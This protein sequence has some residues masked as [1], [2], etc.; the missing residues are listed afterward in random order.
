MKFRSLHVDV[1]KDSYNYNEEDDEDILGIIDYGIKVHIKNKSYSIDPLDPSNPMVFGIGP[2]AGGIVIGS[3]RIVFIFKS[4]VSMGIH[5]SELG[6]A[7]FAFFRTGLDGVVI[8]GKSKD[9]SIITI[10]S[11]DKGDYVK[12]EHIKEEEL[13]NIYNNYE[14][15]K[16][17][18]ALTQYIILKD[19]ENI[20]KNRARVIVVGPSAF[21][22]RFAGI[23]SYVLD[24]HNAKITSVSDSASRGGGGTVLA[25]GHNVVGIVVGGTLRRNNP[26]LGNIKIMNE[27]SQNIYKKQYMPTLLDKTVKYRF[28]P[29]MKTGGTF[30]VNYVHYKELVPYLGYN[31]IYY[32]RGVRLILHDKI[33]ENY[34]KPFQENVFDG[35]KLTDAS[36]NCGEPCSVSCKKIYKGTKIDYEPAHG[37]GPISGIITMDESANLVNLLDDLGL[38]AIEAGHLISWIFDLID[39]GL[40]N[41]EEV[42]LDDYPVF[43]PERLSKETSIKNANL[44][45]K[46]IEYIV[47]DENNKIL[48][49]ISERGLRAAAKEFDDIYKERVSKIGIKY[50]DLL[51]YAPFGKEGY[52]TPNYYWSP[53]VLAPMYVLGK[54]WTDYSPSFKEPEDYASLSLKRAIFEYI[55]ANAGFCRFHRGWAEELMSYMYKEMLNVNKDLY[56][57]GLKMY[58]MIADYQLRSGAEPEYWESKKVMDIVASLAAETGITGWEDTMYHREKL[59]NWWERFYNKLNQELNK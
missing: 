3:H 38:D 34:W 20:I 40:L 13:N 10:Y 9:P 25:K 50:E 37:V 44:A 28:D 31:N 19:K 42:G 36:K 15:Y 45:R 26:N 51:V 6:G 54:Y 59:K 43:D 55:V 49:I 14:G 27:I 23:F 46:L 58:K 7:G 52:M 32:S 35:G 2:F 30:G 5:V 4:P 18:R 48:K 21:K 39:K 56:S 17:T 8:E 24:E 41:P 12:I 53:G 16:G 33:I 11:G 47:F 29:N 57:H 1:S 22:T